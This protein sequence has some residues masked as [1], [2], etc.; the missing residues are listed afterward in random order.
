MLSSVSPVRHAIVLLLVCLVAACPSRDARTAGANAQEDG[1]GAA[2]P[3]QRCV[4]DADCATAAATCCECA[5][6]AVSVSDPAHRA[7]T[8]VTCPPR[9]TCPD[10]VRAACDLGECVL[11][12]VELE[13]SESCAAGYAIDPTGCL[14]CAC[15]MP[16]P[17]GCTVDSDC[18]QTRADCCGCTQGG[19]DTAVVAATQTGFDDGLGCSSS[20][21]CPSVDVCEPGRPRSA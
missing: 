20:P 13:C 6:F 14:S 17:G 4:R 1:D 18:V 12:C 8:G 19:A 15:A 9:D 16:E 2:T 5:A 10:N 21:A 3:P 7:C 11:A